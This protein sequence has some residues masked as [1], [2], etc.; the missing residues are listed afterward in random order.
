MLS[1]DLSKSF[2]SE[3]HSILLQKLKYY[4]VNTN[5]TMLIESYLSTRTQFVHFNNVNL[6]VEKIYMG[7][8]QGSILGPFQY[9]LITCKLYYQRQVYPLCR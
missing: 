6:A 5:S 1:F 9:T 7:I 3:E 4:A 2:D 8:P